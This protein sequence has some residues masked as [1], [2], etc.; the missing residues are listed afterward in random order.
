MQF[1]GGCHCGNISVILDWPTDATRIPARACDCSFCT[2]HGAVWTSD[3][4]AKLVVRIR[5]AALVASYEFGTQTAEFRVCGRC[6]VV[7]LASCTI[8]R[9]RFAVVNVTALRGVD[10][11]MVVRSSS[12]VDGEDIGTRL[13]RRQRNWISQ[14]AIDAAELTS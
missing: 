1:Q 3:P 10:E 7:P 6:G 8:E 14:V 12:N 5:D 11:Q 2:A 13:A 9:A 4:A